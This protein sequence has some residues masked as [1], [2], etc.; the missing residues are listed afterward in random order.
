MQGAVTDTVT[1]INS[2]GFCLKGINRLVVEVSQAC[3]YSWSPT[4]SGAIYDF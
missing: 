3:K 2:L 4:Y 1:G